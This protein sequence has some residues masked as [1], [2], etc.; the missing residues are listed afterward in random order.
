[1]PFLVRATILSMEGTATITFGDTSSGPIML[2]VGTALLI[3]NVDEDGIDLKAHYF[4]VRTHYSTVLL[5]LW[6]WAIFLSPVLR[7]SLGP[8]TPV[9]V[10]FLAVATVM[11]AT[12]KPK[13]HAMAAVTNWL[14]FIALIGLHFLDLGGPAI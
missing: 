2:F 6:L 7:G 11:R 14:L 13:V 9:F 3:P 1:M 12:V 5:L 8:S 10:A 4:A